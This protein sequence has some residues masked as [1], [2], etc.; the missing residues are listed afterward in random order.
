MPLSLGQ[1][2]PSVVG[3]NVKAEQR[4]GQSDHWIGIAIVGAGPYGLSIAAHLNAR[5]I[6][7]RIFGSPMSVWA[8]RMPRGMRLKSEGFA[9]SLSDPESKFTLRDYCRQEGIP[10]SDMGDPVQLETFVAYGRAFQK[11]FVPNLEDRLVTSLRREGSGFDLR[12][13]DGEKVLARRVIIAVGITYFAYVP[14]VLATLQPGLVS[15]SSAHSDLSGFRD[16]RVAVVGAGASAI[17]LAGLLYAAGA[18]VDL[19]A[20]S[21]SIRFQDPPR[22]LSWTE[23]L[24]NPRTGIGSGLEMLFHAHLPHWFQRLPE[25]I[26][27]DRVRKILGPAP[28]WFSKNDVVG[29]VSFHLGKEI[30]AARSE[31]GHVV[32]E[33][34]DRDGQPERVEADHVIAATGYQTDL[35]RMTFLDPQLRPQ[36]RKTGA[37]PALSANFQ[38]SLPG[39][40]FVGLSAAN[41]FGP[42]MRFAFGARFTARRLTRHLARVARRPVISASE[43]KPDI[44]QIRPANT[45]VQIQTDK[46]IG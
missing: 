14:T 34:T 32:L 43:S 39:L 9:S 5:A 16:R 37:G 27:L 36:I 8:T 30:A 26:R 13:E 23:R 22:P 6:P 7:F 33:L 35:H 38:A 15:H 11:R 45:D 24:R 42:L 18:S 40:Y 3:E 41:S 25:R 2:N 21:S 46:S 4:S 1:E 44:A 17:D 12:L 28:G 10:Y 19:I 20:R 29:K 31:A